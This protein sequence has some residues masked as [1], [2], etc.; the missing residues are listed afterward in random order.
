MIINFNKPRMKKILFLVFSVVVIFAACKKDDHHADMPAK[1]SL[2]DAKGYC[3]PITVHGTWIQGTVPN[4][5]TNYV[6]I[7]VD[8]SRTGTYNISTDS[9]N[10]IMLADS[11]TFDRIGINNVRLKP[12]GKIVYTTSSTFPLIFDNTYCDFTINTIDTTLPDGQWQ[13]TAGGQFQHGLASFFVYY[14]PE[15]GLLVDIVG[16]TKTYDSI[17]HLFLPMAEDRGN[18]S[19]GFTPGAYSTSN[20]RTSFFYLAGTDTILR[21]DATTPGNVINISLDSIV[22]AASGYQISARGRFGGSA[23][24]KAGASVPVTGGIFKALTD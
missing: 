19:Y 5:D 4:P 17:W 9:R 10:G 18:S 14:P 13:F 3:L 2:Q 16:G 12:T 1:G 23:V 8:V 22:S 24:N 15:G 11:G 21:A 6:E 20:P 7:T